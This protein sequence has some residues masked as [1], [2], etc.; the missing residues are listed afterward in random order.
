MTMLPFVDPH[1]HL[2]DLAHLRYPWLMPPFADDGP[3]GSVER[4]ARDYLLDDYLAEAQ[5]WQPVGMVHVEAGAHPDDALAET[6]WLQEMAD[7][8]SMPSGIVAFAALDDPDLERK[9]AFHAQHR[10]VRGIRHIVNW[11]PNPQ[12]SYTPRDVTGDAAWQRGF[13]ALARHHLSFDLQAYPGQLTAMAALAAR[14][15]DVPVIINHTGMPVDQDTAGIDAWR[16]GMRALARLPQVA[17]K[18]SGLGFVWRDWTMAQIRP[19]VLETVEMFGPRRCMFASDFPT[20][21]LFGDF[22]RHLDA[23]HQIVADFSL[24]ER[25]DLFACN[26]ARIYRLDAITEILR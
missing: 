12:R 2:W 14:H 15:E 5:T 22:N 18:I 20:D 11:H 19:I 21:R 6:A 23:Y 24:D 13:A 9:L 26:A 1:V 7:R 25:R 3:N 4:I 8:C 10:H 16:R 17:V